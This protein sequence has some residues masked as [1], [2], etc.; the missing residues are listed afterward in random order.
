[1][2]SAGGKVY[3][4]GM[5]MMQNILEACQKTGREAATAG[6]GCKHGGQ[7]K[8]IPAPDRIA[9]TNAIPGRPG[10]QH[11]ASGFSIIF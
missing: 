8:T 6:F 3:V 10:L 4:G 2:T 11:R 5:N 9:Q 7:A 1:M